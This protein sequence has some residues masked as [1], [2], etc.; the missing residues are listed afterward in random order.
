MYWHMFIQIL[1]EG[2]C[3]PLGTNTLLKGMNPTL[4]PPA[5]GK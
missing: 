5:M 4:F 2:D 1:N 3:V